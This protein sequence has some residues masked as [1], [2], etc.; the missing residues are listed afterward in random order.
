MSDRSGRAGAACLSLTCAAK[1][2]RMLPDAYVQLHMRPGVFSGPANT[3]VA[4][5]DKVMWLIGSVD[6]LNPSVIRLKVWPARHAR[7]FPVLT[8]G[9]RACVRARVRRRTKT[10]SPRR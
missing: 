4:F 6:A 7:L 9:P 2:G 8:V 5:T 3:G 10:A 1:M